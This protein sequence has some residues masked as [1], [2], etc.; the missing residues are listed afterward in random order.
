MK[1]FSWILALILAL[2]VGFIGCPSSDDDSTT[3]PASNTTRVTGVALDHHSLTVNIGATATLTAEVYPSYATNKAVTWKSS[4]DTKAAVVGGV[5]SGV[6]EGSGIIITVTTVDGNHSDVCS[7]DVNDPNK[8]TFTGEITISPASPKAG[9]TLTA[10]YS[11]GIETGMTYQ[12]Y[13]DTVAIE[14]ATT[15]TVRATAAG[16]Y[17]VVMSKEGY[18]DKSTVIEVEEDIG[19]FTPNPDVTEKAV[20]FVEDENIFKKAG[21]LDLFPDGSGYKYTYGTASGST[22]GDAIVRFKVDLGATRLGDYGGFT[23]LW[24]GISG[25]VGLAP[26]EHPEYTKNLFILAADNEAAVT[27]P[28]DDDP[29]K[30]LII[31]STNTDK[32]K[33]LYA[34]EWAVPAV[35]GPGISKVATPIVLKKELTGEVWFSVYLHA[36]S[37]E[38]TISNFKLVPVAD[39]EWSGS[40]V[41]YPYYPPGTEPTEGT[42]LIVKVAGADK[43]TTVTPGNNGTVKYA[44]GDKAYT[45][46]YGTVADSNYGNAISRFKLDI[47]QF[48]DITDYSQ[49]KF[50]WTAVSGDVASSKQVFL[51]ASK[52]EA[53][54]TPWIDDT[55]V[56][57]ATVTDKV[58]VNGTDPIDVTLNITSTS[59]TLTGEVWFAIYVPAGDGVYTIGDVEFVR[60]PI[61]VPAAATKLTVNLSD[62]LTVTPSGASINDT[63]PSGTFEDGKLTVT[64]KEN[65]QRVNF[66]LTAKQTEI[67]T[68]RTAGS[69][70][71]F[72]IVATIKED[73][74]GTSSGDS[75]R[76][77]IGTPL[78]GLDWNGTY[79]GQRDPLNTILKGE[80]T[81]HANAT[82]EGRLGYFIL[83]HRNA[84][85]ITIEIS[86]ITIAVFYS[87]AVTDDGGALDTTADDFFVAGN[88]LFT[89]W[90]GQGGKTGASFDMKN[91]AEYGN[92]IGYAFTAD[93]ATYTNI[94][95]Y[96][97]LT[98]LTSG[99]TT[100]PMKL[101]IKDE[102]VDSWGGDIGAGNNGY[103]QS[104]TD[105]SFTFTGA[106]SLFTK[107]SIA[108]QMNWGDAPHEDSADFNITITAV[109]FK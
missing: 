56:T 82:K 33:K 100:K 64:F 40:N 43:D 109:V 72:E 14:G 63:L 92:I 8:S 62:M 103:P 71:Y 9:D 10:T 26:S 59:A 30:D 2:S 81:F 17:S 107:N 34:G 75:F 54:I 77:H 84:N 20:V 78:T 19:G 21:S 79:G 69:P 67:L 95:V 36:E 97:T 68:N 105:G 104:D 73:G 93:A 66:K 55:A 52:T 45:Y 86:S 24:E 3:P 11:G 28:K 102:V 27:A 65:D 4:D 53:G 25:D 90:G 87:G 49:V 41:V 5:V 22:Y 108:F 74:T 42:K 80:Q 7:V 57:A 99:E 23:L 50:K 15:S 6:A 70:V 89:G 31:N 47:G 16:V 32:S 106:K 1:K 51:L 94:A 58:S 85:T 96:Y 76:Y 88:K 101:T 48:R 29:I 12:W 91:D 13:K 83:Q 60:G 44:V 98:K 37:G 38:Y 61:K 35:V 39:Y 46:T 18:N